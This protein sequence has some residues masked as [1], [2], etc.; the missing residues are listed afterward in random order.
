MREKQKSQGHLPEKWDE[1][2]VR[3]AL[4]AARCHA[5]RFA[6]QR[7]L[8]REDREDLTQDILLVILEA[9]HRFDV[10]RASWTTFVAVL[11]RRAVIDRARQPAPPACVS[12]DEKAA[13]DVLRSLIV[14]QADPDIAVAFGRADD[15]LPPAPRALLR[16]IILHRDVAVARDAGAVSPA[17]FYRELHDLRCWLRALGVHPAAAAS[18]RATAPM[19]SQP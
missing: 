10:T 1:R 3:V 11:A 15:D 4:A 5:A 18:M 8:A 7:R 6:R 19:P 2:Q 13:A 16:R 14:P 12:L 17:T 9:G